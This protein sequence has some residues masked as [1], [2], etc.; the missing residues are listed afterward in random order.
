MR[1]QRT[2][3]AHREQGRSGVWHDGRNSFSPFDC[4]LICWRVCSSLSLASLPRSDDRVRVLCSHFGRERSASEQ[5]S[6]SSGGPPAPAYDMPAELSQL[7]LLLY[8]VRRGPLLGP[9]V[10]HPDDVDV[11]RFGFLHA[12]RADALRAAMPALLGLDARGGLEELPLQTLA[13]QSGR[14]LFLDHHSQIMVSGV[15]GSAVQRS[16]AV[17]CALVCVVDSSDRCWLCVMCLRVF[18]SDLERIGRVRSS[19]RSLPLSV[20]V[21]RPSRDAVALAPC[22]GARLRRGLFRRAVDAGAPGPRAP[23]P[24]RVAGG[25]VPAAAI[26]RPCAETTAAVQVLPDG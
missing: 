9:V 19:L 13:L 25:G 11:L 22:G 5:G 12:G 21:S 2:V 15:C 23:G 8:H 7:P 26:A 14:I 17:L 6:S 4:S 20:R 10:Q 24:P 18:A 1:P 16:A 3:H